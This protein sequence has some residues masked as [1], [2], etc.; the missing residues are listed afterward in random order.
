MDI[1]DGQD[2]FRRVT[3]EGSNMNSNININELQIALE[4]MKMKRHLMFIGIT[5]IVIGLLL[6]II[7]GVLASQSKKLILIA[8]GLLLIAVGVLSIA[9]P[10]PVMWLIALLPWIGIIVSSIIIAKDLI[11]KIERCMPLIFLVTMIDFY[12]RFRE[13]AHRRPT[14]EAMMIMDSAIRAI[15]VR[16]APTSNNI[17]EMNWGTMKW[18]IY[19]NEQ[20]SVLF[21]PSMSPISVLDRDHDLLT[22]RSRVDDTQM[23]A[24]TNVANREL[25]LHIS[26]DNYERYLAWKGIQAG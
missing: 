12:L 10:S 11:S 13:K 26:D 8:I 19:L 15:E 18:H 22:P 5:S 2:F 9:K 17:L 3:L 14:P 21:D 24:V 7:G 25:F 23:V 16:N 20:I 4:F 1:Q 6:L